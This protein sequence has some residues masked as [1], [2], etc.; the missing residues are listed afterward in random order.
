LDSLGWVYYKMKRYD[1]AIRQLERALG[2][3]LD[4]ELPALPGVRVYRPDIRG[5]GAV[6]FTIEELN[7]SDAG[8]LLGE[9]FDIAVRTGLHCAPLAHRSLGTFPEGTVRVSP[10]Y[11]T[12]VEDVEYFLGSLR[13]LTRKLGK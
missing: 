12:T 5:T 6:S 8:S 2:S 7:P 1:E 4:L 10:G 11:S 13:S 3:L 9:G